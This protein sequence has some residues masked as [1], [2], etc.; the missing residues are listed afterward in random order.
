MIVEEEVE[1]GDR[2]RLRVVTN[3]GGDRYGHARGDDD[4][5]ARI[6]T[7]EVAQVTIVVWNQQLLEAWEEA[8]RQEQ[9]LKDDLVEVQ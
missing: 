1:R 6:E 3:Q 4:H 7:L 9:S 8:N 5:D 2:Q